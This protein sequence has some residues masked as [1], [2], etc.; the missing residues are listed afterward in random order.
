MRFV[1]FIVWLSVTQAVFQSAN[2]VIASAI[3]KGWLL[4]L[5][6]SLPW[7]RYVS[8]FNSLMPTVILV[9]FLASMEKWG[10]LPWFDVP[11][12]SIVW[13]DK[14]SSIARMALAFG[15]LAPIIAVASWV[16]LTTFYE[17]Y[18]WHGSIWITQFATYITRI[19]VVVALTYLGVR[20]FKENLFGTIGGTI[21][22]I[23]LFLSPIPYYFMKTPT[24]DVF[25]AIYMFFG[26]FF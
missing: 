15:L 14:S 9:L 24:Q 2:F 22:V 20:F 16:F 23:L 8:I 1:W 6:L 18:L 12:L 11:S 21:S 5:N 13:L 19:V 25:R 17:L 4:G 7:V 3:E 26:K 10:A